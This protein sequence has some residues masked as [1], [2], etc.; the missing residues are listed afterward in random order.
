MNRDSD[1]VLD[2]CGSMFRRIK[3]SF[4]SD[5]N[6]SYDPAETVRKSSIVQDDVKESFRPLGPDEQDQEVASAVAD[7]DA[8]YDGEWVTVVWSRNF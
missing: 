8:I 2:M 6:N 4:S 1:S 3:N 5:K 7:L